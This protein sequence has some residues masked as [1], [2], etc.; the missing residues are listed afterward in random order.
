MLGGLRIVAL[1]GVVAVVALAIAAPASGLPVTWKV[2]SPAADGGVSGSF[3]SPSNAYLSFS[4]TGADFELVAGTPASYTGVWS[5][6][7]ITLS[8]EMTVS[9][10]AGTVSYVTM[11]ANLAGESWGWPQAGGDGMV[12]G[13]T[14]TQRFDLTFDVPLGYRGEVTGGA[15]LRV[16]GGVCDVYAIDFRV[17]VVSPGST[18]PPAACP[19]ARH[20]LAEKAARLALAATDECPPVVRAFAHRLR[21]KPGKKV[22][23]E[24]AVE[25]DSGQATVHLGLYQG[26]ALLWSAS[27]GYVSATGKRLAATFTSSASLVGPL[28]F[29]VWAEDAAGNQSEGSPKSSCKWIKLLVPISRVSNACGG[30]GWDFIVA[31]QNYLGNKHTYVNSWVNPLAK[32]WTVNFKKA[33]DLHDAGYG[34]VMVKDTINK[35]VVDYRRWSRKQVDDKFWAD[36]AK[37]CRQQIPPW[38]KVARRKCLG[39]GGALSFGS[40]SLYGIVRDWGYLFF[41]ADLTVPGVQEAGDWTAR[42]TGGARDNG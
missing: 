42:P 31:A 12:A 18:E 24:F 4:I 8:G 36:M 34:G 33:C 40:A 14:V 1:V 20:V 38:G 22:V 41:D 19:Q 5:G 13:T 11:S 39:R 16:C 25:D 7:P 28:F 3:G 17:T 21:T 35:R 27:P 29:C 2:R 37:L 23:L 32:A 26:G 10:S 9:R 30:E 15:Q 6:G